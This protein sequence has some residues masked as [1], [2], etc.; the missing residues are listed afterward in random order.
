MSKEISHGEKIRLA[1]IAKH[2]SE[3]A[4]RKFMQESGSKVKDRSNGG[5]ASMKK[6]NPER[7]HAISKKAG[8]KRWGKDEKQETTES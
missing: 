3:E 4:W 2:G 7:L 1:G 6:N 5:F 8:L